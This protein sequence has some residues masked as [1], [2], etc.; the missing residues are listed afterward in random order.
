[1]SFEDNFILEKIELSQSQWKYFM[2]AAVSL[3]LSKRVTKRIIRN[4]RPSNKQAFFALNSD[5]F[6]VNKIPKNA[7]EKIFKKGKENEEICL[8]VYIKLKI[9]KKEK[10]KLLERWKFAKDFGAFLEE[11]REDVTLPT[12]YLNSLY[13]LLSIMP[14]YKL[15][16][17]EK[18]LCYKIYSLS[19]NETEYDNINEI[20]SWRE[21]LDDSSILPIKTKYHNIHVHVLYKKFENY[22]D[23]YDIFRSGEE[24]AIDI[25]TEPINRTKQEIIENTKP[26][27]KIVLD[28]NSKKQKK[29]RKRKIEKDELIESIENDLK[30][31][32]ITTIDKINQ[33][34]T[35][36]PENIEYDLVKGKK[37]NQLK[38]PPKIQKINDKKKVIF[39]EEQ[40][41]LLFDIEKLKKTN[42]S[43]FLQSYCD[44]SFSPKKRKME[45]VL[46]NFTRFRDLR[47]DLL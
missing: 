40:S 3:I 31:R 37:N 18:K 14:C 28:T 4:R 11:G 2:S 16:K 24:E 38:F 8:D 5:T 7:L 34:F 6:K 35:K 44:S 46:K 15:F 43:P 42:S 23:L 47:K 13:T 36:E 22:L 39:T 9:K 1:M 20:H 19:K 17:D 12:L 41:S 29:A 10:I 45:E 25:N 21:F 30:M 27:A 33:L 26:D 32:N